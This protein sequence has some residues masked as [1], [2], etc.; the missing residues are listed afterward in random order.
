MHL[1]PTQGQGVLSQM[2]LFIPGL[3]GQSQV[4]CT[5]N[6]DHFIAARSLFRKHINEIRFSFL[7]YRPQNRWQHG[8]KHIPNT[9][10]SHQEIL[11]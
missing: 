7:K 11:I 9:Q 4:H 8:W 1:L 10:G 3:F 5:E 2:E 6:L